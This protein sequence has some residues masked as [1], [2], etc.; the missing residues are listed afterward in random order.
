MTNCSF[1]FGRG[2]QHVKW[3]CKLDFDRGSLIIA[4][5]SHHVA[6]ATKAQNRLPGKRGFSSGE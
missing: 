2:G 6:E 5:F 4:I 3:Q 1:S